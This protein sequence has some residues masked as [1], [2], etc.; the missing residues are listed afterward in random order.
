MNYL[1]IGA[2]PAGVTAAEE[3]RN[4]DADAQ[5]TLL[6]H[7]LETPYARMAIPY[8]I[9]KQI[10]ESGLSIR[11]SPTHYA[12]KNIELITAS[13][14]S[15]DINKQQVNLTEGDALA[16][17]KLLIATG[18]TPL[19]PPIPGIDLPG[20]YPCWTL[21]NARNIKAAAVEGAKVVLIGA[22][23]ISTT[24]VEALVKCGAQLTIVEMEDR[25]IPRM[26]DSKGGQIIR[27]WCE[28]KGVAILTSAPA[29][30][31]TQAAD[32]KLS[33]SFAEHDAIEAIE[34]I[35]AD[36]IISAT[37]VAPNISFLKDSGLDTDLGVLVDEHLM[38]S[39]PNVY[40]AGDVAQAPDLLSDERTVMAIQPVATEHGRLAA[41][42]MANHDSNSAA[43]AWPGSINMNVLDMLGL[44]S[45][46][47]GLW[48]G[49]EH[50]GELGVDRAEL[51]QPEQSKY[52]QLQFLDDRLIGAS[53]VGF[54]NH[55]GVFQGL[56]QGQVALGEWKQRLID[57]PSLVMEAWVA[58]AQGI[59]S[60]G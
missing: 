48:D 27:D 43:Q 39:D 60:D 21:E 37:G 18:G 24:I 40:A 4:L 41:L 17:D 36:L 50:A 5:I 11:I 45:C 57:D 15:I 1:I 7:E 14:E 20:V 29:R 52:I 31:I 44:V 59:K 58:T 30:A 46:S 42:N 10:E 34:A 32:G 26:M 49:G 28:G 25:L 23:F 56:I 13:V 3:L 51:H 35:E 16:Y 19:T 47:F 38:S 22:G 33:V 6:S 8:L 54:T 53:S 9:K 55:V 2:G 12:D